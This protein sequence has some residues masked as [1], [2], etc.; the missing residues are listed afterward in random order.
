MSEN[1]DRRICTDDILM[2]RF[3]RR[4]TKLRSAMHVFG[5][6]VARC[7]NWILGG[8]VVD[9]VG[10]GLRE[11]VETQNSPLYSSIVVLNY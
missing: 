3:C 2:S 9:E 6:C 5:F 7:Y 8:V 11:E 10:T 1:L 4:A